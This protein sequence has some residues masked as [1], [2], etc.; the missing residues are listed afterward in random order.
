[1]ISKSATTF[2]MR[3]RDHWRD[4]VL[5]GLTFLMALDFFIIAP[6]RTVDA[7]DFRAFSIVIVLLLSGALVLL[8]RSIV[9]LL[10]IIGAF[11]LFV[12]TLILR[13][14][15]GHGMIDACL[16]ALS[17]MMLNL[18]VIWV[19][20]RAVFASGE[21]TYHRVIGG[22]LVYLTTAL[23]FVSLYS[24]VGALSPTSFSGLHVIDRTTLPSDLIYF[25]FATL[26]SVGY[27]DIVPVHP[28]ARSLSNLEAVIGQL[29][30]ATLLAR[31]VSLGQ[32][33]WPE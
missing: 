30:P 6:A 1:M 25:S 27:G 22:V 13:T 9:P 24:L 16:E 18:A 2:L 10:V 26:T 12:A 14:Q 33:P 3:A 29:Y 17:W 15:A 11:A 20:A 19:T 7:F 5:T 4:R 28:F 32:R 21:I 23:V 8:S 31:L